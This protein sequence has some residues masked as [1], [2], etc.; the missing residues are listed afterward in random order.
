MFQ[1]HQINTTK[2]HDREPWAGHTGP[3]QPWIFRNPQKFEV[4]VTA[5]SGLHVHDRNQGLGE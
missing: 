2:T 4:V 5:A 3:D 1:N